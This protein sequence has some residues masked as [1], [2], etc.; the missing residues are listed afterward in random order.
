MGSSEGLGE[1]VRDPPNFERRRSGHLFGYIGALADQAA[2][3][4]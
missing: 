2:L 1:R 4:A 3:P